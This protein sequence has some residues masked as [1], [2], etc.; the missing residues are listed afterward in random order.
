MNRVA[1]S[2]DVSPYWVGTP[3]VPRWYRMLLPACHTMWR[4]LPK[5]ARSGAPDGVAAPSLTFAAA[6]QRV[7]PT[8]Q[9]FE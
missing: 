7:R 3:Y 5:L 1:G 6:V 9:W 4:C 8:S 2:Q